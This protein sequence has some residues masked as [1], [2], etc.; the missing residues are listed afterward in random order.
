MRTFRAG[1]GWISCLIETASRSSNAPLSTPLKPPQP[2]HNELY[3]L[4]P[5][6]CEKHLFRS[7]RAGRGPSPMPNV[8]ASDSFTIDENL[9]HSTVNIPP[10]RNEAVKPIA[11]IS[12]F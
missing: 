3:R 5:P 10:N 8:S 2:L 7:R 9:L 6:R 1:F 11:F 12:V 4:I